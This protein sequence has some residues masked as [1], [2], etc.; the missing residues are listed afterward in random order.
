MKRMN[1]IKLRIRDKGT[2]PVSLRFPFYFHAG[3]DSEHTL[4]CGIQEVANSTVLYMYLNQLQAGT[5]FLPVTGLYFPKASQ[6]FLI[7]REKDQTADY[8][9]AIKKRSEPFI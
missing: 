1:K 9:K 3:W 6:S 5:S 7:L 2:V 8:F 4:H